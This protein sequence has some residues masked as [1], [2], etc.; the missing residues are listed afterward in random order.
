M[1]HAMLL[2]NHVEVFV[3]HL[4]SLFPDSTQKNIFVKIQ[5]TYINIYHKVPCTSLPHKKKIMVVGGFL[6]SA[7]VSSALYNRCLQCHCRSD[8]SW[9]RSVRCRP[10]R[11]DWFLLRPSQR[12]SFDCDVVVNILKM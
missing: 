4:M 5:F 2:L 7:W 9:E 12:R 3:R 10:K 11:M 1:P 6:V 8:I